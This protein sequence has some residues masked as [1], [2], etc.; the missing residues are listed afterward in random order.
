MGTY[1][2][3]NDPRVDQQIESRVNEVV[4]ILTRNLPEVESIILTGG[5]GKGEGSVKISDATIT[6]LRDFDFVVVFKR[7]I[8]SDK[9]RKVKELL[10]CPSNATN[11]YKYNQEFCL[12]LSVTTLER[13]NLFPDVMTYDFKQSKVVYGKDVRSKI[14]WDTRD[15]PLRSGARLL[16]QKSIALI[17]A[18]SPDYLTGRV[19]QSN[20][21][22][23]MRETSKVYV[24]ISGALCVLA[25][26]YN[27]YCLRRVCI[28]REI[29]EEHFPD[30]YKIAPDLV[31]KMEASAK[32]K[33]D[34]VNNPINQDP[35]DYWFTA[36]D[37]L[38]NVITDYFR[39]YLRF[40]AIDL[41]EFAAL[42]E[43]NMMK[44]YYLPLID[45]YLFAKK[46]PR[47]KF[48][49]RQLNAAYNI[50]QNF[51]YSIS[52]LRDHRLSLSLTQGISAPC[53]KLFSAC[54]LVMFSIERDGTIN[55]E[56]LDEALKR[57]SFVK[58]ADCAF[59]ELWE[60]ARLKCLKLVDLLPSM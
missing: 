9:V 53:I 46:L 49:L 23:F 51:D 14:K 6:P 32:Y 56:N 48:L 36:R 25:G 50:K 52:A 55:R 7:V 29:Y 20:L 11:S 38:C 2:I 15:I 12:D 18:L 59:E 31:G 42:L 3:H 58:L 21:D 8:P 22:V 13:I 39:E 57:L 43:K 35:I 24:E 17:G 41:I 10:S 54:L 60:E 33:V 26:K 47:S 34:P 37:D 16:F 44:E 4:G 45:N 30:L 28:L 40:S 27:S 1:T 5:F 19:S